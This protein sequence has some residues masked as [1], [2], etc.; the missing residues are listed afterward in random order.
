VH[1][2]TIDTRLAASTVARSAPVWSKAFGLQANS[3]DALNVGMTT[4]PLTLICPWRTGG[5]RTERAPLP[6][7]QGPGHGNDT[8]Q[9]PLRRRAR[10]NRPRPRS[11]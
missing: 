6:C 5:G 4:L 10:A 2:H 11:W 3:R 9:A 7:E 1:K 8:R